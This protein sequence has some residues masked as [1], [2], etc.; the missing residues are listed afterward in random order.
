[1]S[2][3]ITPGIPTLLLIGLAACTG[4]GGSVQTAPTPSG[5]QGEPGYVARARAD[6]L[7]RPYTNTDVYFMSG[8][9][10]HH[11]Q[12]ILMAG[13]AAT[14]GAG[15]SVRILA[16]RIINAQKDEI[17]LMQQWLR[18]RGKPVPE[19]QPTPMKMMMNGVEHEMLMPGML[20]GAQLQ[21]L[22]QATGTGFERLFL[23]FMIQHHKGAI[24]MVQ[25]LFDAQGA[26]A[27]E[28]VFKFASAVDVDQSTEIARMEKMLVAVIMSPP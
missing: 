2:A 16:A 13:W 20:N 18:D 8:M 3:S 12:A 9:I 7:R 15:E 6:S 26:G 1:M 23:T 25:D 14:H 4:T 28:T 19:A 5:S 17:A 24:E 11:A 27:D 10:H 22:D 21:Q